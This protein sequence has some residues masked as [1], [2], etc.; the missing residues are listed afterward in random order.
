VDRALAALAEAYFEQNP[1]VFENAGDVL[2][3]AY[4]LLLLNT[5]LQKEDRR[6]KI[7]CD[8]FLEIVGNAIGHSRIPKDHLAR[9]YNKLNERPFE[10]PPKPFS[11]LGRCAPKKQGWLRKRNSWSIGVPSRHFFVLKDGELTCFD[12][13]EK[14]KHNEPI[15]KIQLT[16]V[17]VSE[18]PR[19]PIRFYLMAR[20][21]EIS[22]VRLKGG[23]VEDVHGIQV[24]V[25]EG[26]SKEIA[27]GWVVK[28]RRAAVMVHFIR[29]VTPTRLADPNDPE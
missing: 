12:E 9:A 29:G 28:L 18:D 20:K 25:F 19:S 21:E 23:Q 6:D 5:E 22:Y 1:R 7:T 13:W 27:D 3:L 17:D 16:N 10:F 2:Y 24:M 14:K 15:G 8:E 26:R 11:F 4:A